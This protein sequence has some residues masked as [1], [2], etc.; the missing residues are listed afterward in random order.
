M[1]LATGLTIKRCRRSRGFTVLE[2]M[3][4]LMLVAVFVAISIPTFR[5]LSRVELKSSANQLLGLIRDTYARTALSGKVHR[6]VMDMDK[7]QYWVEVSNDDARLPEELAEVKE[8]EGATLDIY[9]EE[10]EKLK[11]AKP[12]KFIAVED[13]LGKKQKLPGDVRFWGIWIDHLK[14]RARTGQVALHFFPDGYTQKA[15]ITLTDED[16]GEHV[17]TLVTEPL[18]GEVVIENV[19]PPIEK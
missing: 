8:D 2:I 4:A 7:S 16:S 18:T 19:E 15:Q 13:E 14:D 1:I 5:S 10:A 3:V 9:G 6:L 12:P 11:Y 17:R